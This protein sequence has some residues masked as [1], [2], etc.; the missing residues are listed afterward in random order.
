VNGSVGVANIQLMAQ[1]VEQLGIDRNDLLG[2]VD[3]AAQRS[4]GAAVFVTRQF[5]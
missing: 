1:N 3:P 2:R 4:L 5:H